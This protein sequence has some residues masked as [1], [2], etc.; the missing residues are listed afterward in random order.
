MAEHNGSPRAF[1]QRNY[2]FELGAIH[3]KLE[4]LGAGQEEICRRL[5]VDVKARLDKVNGSIS[6]LYQRTDD[7]KA[8]L[9]NHVIECPQKHRI[10]EIS[11]MLNERL[12]SERTSTTWREKLL[13]PLIRIVGTGIVLLFLLHAQDLLKKAFER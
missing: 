10:E 7:N 12:G 5:D 3:G 11:A 8:A 1:D 2:A 4:T 6:T 9:F 13:F